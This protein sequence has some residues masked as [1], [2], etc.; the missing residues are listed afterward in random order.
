MR[1]FKDEFILNVI[2]Y[3]FDTIDRGGGLRQKNNKR[4]IFLTVSF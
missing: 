4:T 2:R 3:R 1:L